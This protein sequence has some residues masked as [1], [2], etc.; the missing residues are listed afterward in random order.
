MADNSDDPLAG[1]SVTMPSSSSQPKSASSIVYP[2]PTPG[3][4]ALI[5][6]KN[7]PSSPG[8]S[9]TITEDPLSG[10]SVK[11]PSAKTRSAPTTVVTPEA[12]TATSDALYP[13][14]QAAASGILSGV[15]VVGPTLLGLAQRGG[16][17]LDAIRTGTPYA[18]NLMARQLD[19]YAAQHD[20]PNT[21]AVGNSVGMM[22]GYAPAMVA[23]PAVFGAGEGG[24]LANALTGSATGAGIGASDAMAR[25]GASVRNAE[26]GAISGATGGLAGPV[27]GAGVGK[28][29]TAGSNLL[30]GTNPAAANVAR[31][32]RNV[33]MTPMQAEA[34]L[35]ANPRMVPADFDPAFGAEA[36]G[37]ASLGGTPTSILKRAMKARAASADDQIEQVAVANLGP[38]PDLT[39]AKEAIVQKAQTSAS[40]FYNAARANPT[41]MDITPI[42]NDINSQL[43]MAPQGSG[44][45]AVLNKAK[46]YLTDQ[47]VTTP[48]TPGGSPTTLMV[49]KDDPGALLKARQAL[50][51]DIDGLKRNG[52]ID[53]T[54]AGKSAYAAANDIRGQLDGVLKSDPNMAAGDQAYSSRIRA[55]EDLDN[56]TNIFKPSTRLED[57]QRSVAAASNDPDR[58]SAMQQG[59]LSALH[60]RLG[61]V[62]GDFSAAR[63][64]FA[65]GS[66][67]RAKMDALF[68][69]AG[70]F[71]DNLQDEIAM[72]ST[73]Q[74]VAGGSATAESNAIAAK[75]KPKFGGAEIN[76]AIPLLGQAA[77]GAP[78]AALATGGKMVY[79]NLSNAFTEATRNRLMEGTA[80]GLVSSGPEQREF[81]G[82]VGRA[83]TYGPRAEALSR[84][85]STVTN[86]LARPLAQVGANK[87][88]PPP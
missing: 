11:M 22:A 54:T 51:G 64:L 81:M 5:A 38:R 12:T 28:I 49:P 32:M 56:G 40:P 2:S 53:G 4:N 18:D 87:L 60:D 16:A 77:G 10:F 30:M 36:R 37:L 73:E 72:R 88:F 34:D 50:D 23:A 14:A 42:L 80:R 31:L 84:G 8:F 6:A 58:L 57:F 86:L 52:M 83:F 62:S 55:N 39:A 24:L 85:G 17:A 66:I 27:L 33:G 7:A 35:A 15:P 25:N 75:Y 13:Q 71:F 69:N 3:Q 61:G 1:F 48:G 47:K 26:T 41:P 70:K 79:G 29:M 9:A 20:Y 65:K 82:Q 74:H 67:N 45:A 46:G 63:Q 21:T 78:G 68:P 44:E 76:P 59:A 43:K 19:T